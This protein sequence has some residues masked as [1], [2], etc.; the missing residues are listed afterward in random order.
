MQSIPEEPRKRELRCSLEGIPQIPDEILDVMNNGGK[1]TPDQERRA[2]AIIK[3]ATIR[4][5]ARIYEESCD[6]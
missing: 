1:L 2:S 5:K 3:L 6:R 4:I